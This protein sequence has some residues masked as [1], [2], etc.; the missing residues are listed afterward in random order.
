MIH[1]WLALWRKQQGAIIKKGR[2]S[3]KTSLRKWFSED[4]PSEDQGDE[5]EEVQWVKYCPLKMY[6]HLEPQNVTLFGNTVF[7]DAIS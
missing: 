4:G 7:I 5:I 2:K 6:I 3:R 1:V